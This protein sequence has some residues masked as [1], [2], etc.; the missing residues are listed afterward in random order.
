MRLDAQPPG[1]V[2]HTSRPLN[3]HGVALN[4]FWLPE[5]R[6]EGV[7]LTLKP[8]MSRWIQMGD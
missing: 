7:R 3:E 5:T 1:Q 4:V 8:R 2:N 6:E